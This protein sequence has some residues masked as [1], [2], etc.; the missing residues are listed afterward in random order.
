ME[1]EVL[2]LDFDVFFDILRNRYRS[3][4]LKGRSFCNIGFIAQNYYADG[5]F[6]DLISNFFS[7]PRY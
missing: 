4:D 2:S 5:Q 6:R 1:I 7:D 3:F